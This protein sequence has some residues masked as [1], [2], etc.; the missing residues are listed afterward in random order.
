MENRFAFYK[1]FSFPAI[2]SIFLFLKNLLNKIYKDFGVPYIVAVRST[3]T[4]IFM[5]YLS[6]HFM[7]LTVTAS[8]T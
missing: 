8:E 7:T 4:E 1:S 3:D 5:K 2:P 6:I